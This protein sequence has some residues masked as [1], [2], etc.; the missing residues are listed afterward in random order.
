MAMRN[1]CR[2]VRSVI[3][4][5]NAS[6]MRGLTNAIAELYSTTPGL[7]T[8][9]AL[10]ERERYFREEQAKRTAQGVLVLEVKA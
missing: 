2:R 7:A 6:A 9:D 5:P 1:S 4:K 3:A 8:E 10:A